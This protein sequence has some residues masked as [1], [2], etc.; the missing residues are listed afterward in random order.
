MRDP[1]A[2]IERQHEE[3]LEHLIPRRIA[4]MAPSAFAFFRRAAA[5]IAHDLRDQPNTSERMAAAGGA[6][7]ASFGLLATLERRLTLELNDFDEVCTATW[8]RDAKRLAVSIVLAARERSAPDAFAL[9]EAVSAVLA[10]Q[11]TSCRH[12]AL[13][14]PWAAQYSYVAGRTLARGRGVQWP[15]A[16][17][18]Q[19]PCLKV[20]PA[21]PHNLGCK[22][23]HADHR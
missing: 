11:A 15:N 18:C 4:R 1:V 20:S 19:T 16:S 6:H 13:S 8:E 3:R 21:S 5:I 17:P 10:Y 23:T 14:L 9:S 7:G 2:V 12:A 22:R